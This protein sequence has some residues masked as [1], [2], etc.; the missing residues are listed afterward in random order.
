MSIETREGDNTGKE[1]V[2]VSRQEAAAT[3]TADRRESIAYLSLVELRW[4]SFS[5]SAVSSCISSAP[6]GKRVE[7]KY[8]SKSRST[9]RTNE[10]LC[11]SVSLFLSIAQR[12]RVLNRKVSTAVRNLDKFETPVEVVCFRVKRTG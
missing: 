7:Q 5:F 9:R 6:A 11:V 10:T 1:L 12:Y 2:T 8:E 4:R 3:L